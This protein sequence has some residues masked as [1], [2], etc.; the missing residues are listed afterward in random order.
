[1]SQITITLL[2]LLCAAAFFVTEKLPVGVTSISAAVALCLLGVIDAKTAFSGLVDTN[3]ILFAGMF[4]VA[5]AMFETGLADEIGAKVVRMFGKSERKLLI[6]VMVVGAALSTFLSNISV[7]AS[8]MPVVI[9]IADSAGYSRSKFLLPLAIAAALGGMNSLVGTPPNLLVHSYMQKAGLPGFG[10]FEFAWYGIPVTIVGIIYMATIGI[11]LIPDRGNSADFA[12]RAF[13]KTAM[14]SVA[15]RKQYLSGGIFVLTVLGMFFASTIKV[16]LHV[17]AVVGAL[18]LVFTGVM[19]DKQA[20]RSIDWNTI[21]LTGGMMPVAAA[22]A[23]TGAGK[24]ISDITLSAFGTNPN[25]LLLTGA[26][27]IVAAIL[28]QFMSNV[29]LT[30][31]LGPICIGVA[32]QMG[33]DPKSLVLAAGF[34]SSVAFATPV[35]TPATAIVFGPGNYKFIDFVKVGTP[36]LV[37]AFILEMIISPLI[38]PF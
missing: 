14:D 11:K 30:A 8:L 34:A 36:L 22:L 13:S 33:V 7:V 5:G 26:I 31:L 15:R 35:G 12:H 17:T 10:F 29:A 37:L 32:Q 27:F 4:V 38:W 1:M 16:P 19:T 20:Y 28:T 3:V 6:A 21:L 18:S 9:S 24:L 25:P 23:K 2:V